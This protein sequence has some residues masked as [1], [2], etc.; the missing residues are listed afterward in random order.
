[1]K[2]RQEPIIPTT[3]LVYAT[4]QVLLAKEFDLTRKL[5]IHTTDSYGPHEMTGAMLVKEFQFR[6]CPTPLIL[7]HE[8]QHELAAYQP[9]RTMLAK[10][11]DEA[12]RLA[13]AQSSDA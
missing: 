10:E 9:S 2:N 3:S 13:P 5:S 11:A 6:T 8:A 12:R 4:T 7:E 1:M